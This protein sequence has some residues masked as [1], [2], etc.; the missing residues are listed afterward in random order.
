MGLNLILKHCFVIIGVTGKTF[1]QG[2]SLNF[3]VD[4]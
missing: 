4:F 1:R 3:K 2:N